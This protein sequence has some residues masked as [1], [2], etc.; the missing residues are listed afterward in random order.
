M[1]VNEEQNVFMHLSVGS[2]QCAVLS[3]VQPHMTF[4]LCSEEY[5][6][7]L[8]GLPGPPGEKGENG[9]VGAMVSRA[10]PFCC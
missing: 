9:D 8:Q 5:L 3:Q 4:F 10:L 1:A 7:S 2:F 6:S